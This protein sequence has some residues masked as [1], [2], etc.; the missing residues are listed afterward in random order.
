MFFR[1][2]QLL[3]LHIKASDGTIGKIK[4]VYFDDH[5]WTI[6]YL[7]VEP[8]A[9]LAVG[10]VL[11]SP[12]SVSSIDWDDGFVNVKLSLEQVKASP[13]IDTDKPVCRQHEEHYFDYYGYPYYWTDPSLWLK[14]TYPVEPPGSRPDACNMAGIRGAA[15][16]DP[17]LRSAQEVTGYG[18]ETTTEPIGHVEDFLVDS[19]T[20]A[21]RYLIVKTRNWLPGK[22]VVIPPTWIQAVDWDRRLV[23]AAVGA[24]SVKGAPEFSPST[25]FSRAS[26]TSLYKHYQLEPYWQ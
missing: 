9:L 10:Q 4:D 3:G 21:I 5:R 16:L 24:D 18:I 22:H 19:V 20:W 2:Q 14:T 12:I 15:P 13:S 11:I 1:V 6:R 25:E 8:G 26:E 7:V 17:R 23:R